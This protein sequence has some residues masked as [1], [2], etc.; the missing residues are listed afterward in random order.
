[1]FLS[2]IDLRPVLLHPMCSTSNRPSIAVRCTASG[3]FWFAGAGDAGVYPWEHDYAS[4]QWT[5]MG[6]ENLRP[7][8]AIWVSFMDGKS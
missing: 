1:M 5:S 6:V 7:G 2:A 4:Y 8:A 3:D